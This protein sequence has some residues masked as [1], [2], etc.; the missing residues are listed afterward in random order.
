MSTMDPL[1]PKARSE[2]LRLLFSDPDK[3]MHLREL[4]RL[5]GLAIRTI[6]TEI[7]KMRGAGLVTDRR[8]GNRLYFRANTQHP[9]FPEL[10]SITLKTTGL[11]D[12]LTGALNGL[13]GISLAL[14]HGSFASG[15]PTPESDIDLLLIGSVG[16]RDL[17]PRL[18]PVAE[19]LGREVNPTVMSEENF[20]Q[21]A[22]SG[23]AFANS[24]CRAP[25]IWIKGSENDLGKLA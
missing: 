2:I 23:D 11:K 24:V 20:S 12:A 15:H 7:T 21:K 16:L 10:R 6:Q 17:A 25:K 22:R 13:D 8:D 18:R 3:S 4:A 5:S 9:L 1:F 14:V 19:T